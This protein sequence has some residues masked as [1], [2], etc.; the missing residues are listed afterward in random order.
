MLKQFIV[1]LL[2]IGGAIAFEMGRIGLFMHGVSRFATNLETMEPA[3]VKQHVQKYG[4]ALGDRNP[5][6]RRGANLA[7]QLA[8]GVDFDTNPILFRQWWEVNGATW[9]YQPPQ[10]EQP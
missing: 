8:T 6:V 2:V 1:I 3:A 10:K 4:A 7:L 5:M 9:Q